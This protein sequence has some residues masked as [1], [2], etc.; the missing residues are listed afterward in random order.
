MFAVN[1]PEKSHTQSVCVQIH[2]LS[3]AF[4]VLF[5]YNFTDNLKN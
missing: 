4:D 2:H 3:H 5:F 1:N